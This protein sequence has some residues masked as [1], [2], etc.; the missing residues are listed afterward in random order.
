MFLIFI[1][2]LRVD[3]DVETAVS[4]IADD[5]TTWRRDGVI[6]GCARLL[7][8][9]E[10]GLTSK[11]CFGV[12]TLS[13]AVGARTTRVLTDLEHRNACVGLAGN[14]LEP[15]GQWEAR[16]AGNSNTL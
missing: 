3:L 12:D 8:E 15:H 6:R 7:A 13:R 4:L 10:V 14:N 11:V 9:A 1:N 5:T 16:P 2:D